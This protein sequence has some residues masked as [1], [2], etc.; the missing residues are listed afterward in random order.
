[1]TFVLQ[2]AIMLFQNNSSAVG[3]HVKLN[4]ISLDNPITIS[5]LFQTFLDYSS[6]FETRDTEEA[7]ESQVEQPKSIVPKFQIL[8]FPEK[9]AKLFYKGFLAAGFYGWLLCYS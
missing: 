7:S 4:P 9:D 3:G 8:L 6:E 1:M 5:D 2:R